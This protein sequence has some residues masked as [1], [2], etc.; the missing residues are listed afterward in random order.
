[1]PWNPLGRKR[2]EDPALTLRGND[3][4]FRV[5]DRLRES[6]RGPWDRDLLN[7]VEYL[8]RN[9]LEEI[10]RDAEALAAEYR[11]ANEKNIRTQEASPLL[12]GKLWHTRKQHKLGRRFEGLFKILSVFAQAREEGIS[13]LGVK[14]FDRILF[15]LPSLIKEAQAKNAT[16]EQFMYTI[17]IEIP[18]RVVK[19]IQ[20]LRGGR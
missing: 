8:E 12:E 17:D 14:G 18:K 6:L 20:E 4:H 5:N 13:D 10:Q 15:S 7:L 9:S 2:T 1:M 16:T 3:A 19:L 11:K